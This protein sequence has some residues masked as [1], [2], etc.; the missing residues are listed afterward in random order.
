MVSRAAPKY[1]EIRGRCFDYT[2]YTSGGDGGVRFSGHEGFNRFSNKPYKGRLCHQGTMTMEINKRSQDTGVV[3]E[4]QGI[5]YRFPPN[6][7]YDQLRNT[8]YRKV[9]TLN[10]IN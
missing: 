6:S 10:V 5:K 2:A 4:I 3:V 1:G 8:W 9:V 7:P